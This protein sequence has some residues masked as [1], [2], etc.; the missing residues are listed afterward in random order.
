MVRRGPKGPISMPTIPVRTNMIDPPIAATYE[1]GSSMVANPASLLT[2]G[3]S[4][5]NA[6]AKMQSPART[7]I[8]VCNSAITM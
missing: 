7:S 4:F 8:P 1:V 5:V 2:P 6:M 3:K